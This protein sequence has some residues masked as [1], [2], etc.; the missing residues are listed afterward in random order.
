MELS[1][2]NRWRRWRPFAALL[3]GLAPLSCGGHV[4]TYSVGQTLTKTV[5]PSGKVTTAI[6]DVFAQIHALAIQ[7]DGKLVAAGFSAHGERGEF[8]LARYNSDGSLDRSFN[9]TGI[10][11]TPIGSSDDWARAL[12]IQPDGKLVAAGYTSYGGQTA[13]ALVRYNPDGSLDHT[14]NSS[15]IVTTPIGASRD[16]AQAL[17]IQKDGKL[18]VAGQSSNGTQTA[19]A[20]ARYNPDGSL[21]RSFNATGI[22]ITPFGTSDDEANALVIQP[23]GKL[24]AAGMSTRLPQTVFALARYNPDGSLDRTFH[25]TGK[26]TT[27]IASDDEARA[28]AIQPD[29]ELIAA[30]YSSDGTQGKL[31]VVRYH[32][33]GTLDRSFGGGGIVTVAIGSFDDWARAVVIQPDG[34]VVAAGN[35]SNFLQSGFALVR[36]NPDGTLDL[37]FNGSGIVTTLIATNDVA[38]ALAIQ[39]DGRL[40]AAGYAMI[41][42]VNQFALV[43]Y[44][45]DGTLDPTFMTRPSRPR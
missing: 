16:R 21:D 13:V 35:S 14:F 12:A 6:G 23:D 37:D 26:V 10:V 42:T 28:L 9:A 1:L 22:V 45:P 8:T 20:L 32:T 38:T 17:V 31:A 11:I 30:G 3:V 40:V 25:F 18:V 5:D 27:A 29:G 7:P 4:E 19:F 24:V 39:P 43:R 33:D 15:G 2:R 41:N 34:K 44:K 36:F